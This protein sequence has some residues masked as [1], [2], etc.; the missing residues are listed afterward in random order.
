MYNEKRYYM[1][2]SM[3]S[4]FAGIDS[5]IES[6]LKHCEKNNFVTKLAIMSITN[7]NCEKPVMT[8]TGEF[9]P[10]IRYKFFHSVEGQLP[11]PIGLFEKE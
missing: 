10:F 7:M 5:I 4:N 3:I 9:I 1:E 2:T 11:I 8:V 6:H